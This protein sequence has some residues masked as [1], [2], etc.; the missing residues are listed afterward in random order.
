[1][2]QLTAHTGIK[3]KRNPAN[4]GKLTMAQLTCRRQS[5]SKLEFLQLAI[6]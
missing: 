3:Q 6:P 4:S 1:M 5:L 2:E